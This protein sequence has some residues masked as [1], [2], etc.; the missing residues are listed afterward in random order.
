M[1]R[2]AIRAGLLR[3]FLCAP[4]AAH[5]T[6]DSLERFAAFVF[7][8]GFLMVAAPFVARHVDRD[9]RIVERQR[10]IVTC[11][12]TQFS[13][14]LLESFERTQDIFEM[15]LANLLSRLSAPPGSL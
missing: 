5:L 15:D 7:L 12:G 4:T 10:V 8:T 14:D 1:A 6:A 11:L 13:V 9:R 3:P 2:D